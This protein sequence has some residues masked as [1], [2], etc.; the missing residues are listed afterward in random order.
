MMSTVFHSVGRYEIHEEIGRGGMAAVFRATDTESNRE[1]ALKLVAIEADP[2]GQ[3][4]LEAERWGAKLQE[5]FCRASRYV[6]A[7]FEQGTHGKYFYIAMEYLPGRN[8]SEVIG[9]GPMPPAR[10]VRVAMQLCEFLED[11][12]AFEGT[13]DGRH[14]NL[15]L[16]GDLKPRNIRVLDGDEIKVFD[17]GIA[18]ALS[19]SRKVTRNDFGSIAYL[20]PERLESGDIDAQA[21]LWA[22]GV[23]LYEMVGGVQPFRAP[24]TRRL[25]QRI[26]SRQ[27]PAPLD[28]RCPIGLK[29]IVAKL[30]A[31][32]VADRYSTASG[33]RDDL[34]RFTDGGEVV[35]QREG[36]PDG[37]RDEATRRTRRPATLA[38]V[39]EVTRRTIRDTAPPPAVP[40]AASP[41]AVAATAPG[42]PA[43]AAVAAAAAARVAAAERPVPVPPK[44]KRFRRF[45][46]K[47]L[48]AFALLTVLNEIRVYVIA[49][50]LAPNVP[51][52]ASGLIQMWDQFARLNGS[53]S[54]NLG[55]IPLE[56]A[57][58]R[59]T[60]ALAD[61]TFA[62]YRSG[63]GTI[64]EKEWRQTRDALILATLAKPSSRQLKAA[65]RYCDGHLRRIDGEARM[66]A[67]QTESAM[68]ELG[69]AVTAFREA[70]ETR[71]EW[72]DPFLGLMRTFIGM[73]DIEHS[74]DALAQAQRYGYTAGG[75]DW[76]LL[77]EGYLA[78]GVKLAASDELEP[79]TRAADAYTQA[80][81]NLTK[82]TGFGNVA[83]RLR[84][85]RRRLAEVQERIQRLTAAE[86]NEGQERPA[87]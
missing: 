15:L 55:A 33:I 44:R 13:L 69:V 19:L 20:S 37:V 46:R 57:L 77:G 11:A 14:F 40:V 38:E 74:A 75:R 32:D 76:A 17:F 28:E 49:G 8:L 9:E 72:P 1:V 85:A 87:A 52:E 30:L 39:D 50:A 64:F 86:G 6:P 62:R 12:A 42:M 31:P 71:P 7:V 3:Q 4:V 47:A 24:D 68:Q 53:S 67:K 25:E 21:E 56:H 41:V 80:I 18:K 22:V 58:L 65:V 35:A 83:Q 81:E 73:D 79:L 26:R 45:L 60:A 51:Q 23:L 10:A 34:Q 5:E 54:L 36:W 61:R 16:H 29:A 43:P 78:R 27:Q 63:N 48:L 70:A 66:K 2:D 84:D 59:Q 82:A